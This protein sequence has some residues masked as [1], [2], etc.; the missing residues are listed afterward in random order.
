MRRLLPYFILT[1][2]S[3]NGLYPIDFSL[4][5]AGQRAL[6]VA[7]DLNESRAQMNGAIINYRRDLTQYLPQLSLTFGNSEN[8]RMD[9][10]DT[11]SY[12]ASAEISQPIFNGGRNI[13]G[14][15]LTRRQLMQQQNQLDLQEETVLDQ[16]WEIYFGILSQKK[17]I[18]LYTRSLAIVETQVAVSEV[19]FQLGEM[20]E[21]DFLEGKIQL[22]NYR[23]SIAQE[24]LTLTQ[25]E[26]QLK[27]LLFLEQW[28]ELVLTDDL[29]MDYT[30]IEIPFH[31]DDLYEMASNNN[32]SIQEAQINLEAL[33]SQ[34]NLN[35]LVFMPQISLTA[36]YQLSDNDLPLQNQSYG[37]SLDITFPFSNLPI[38]A[39]IGY[40][41]KPDQEFGTTKNISADVPTDIS[42]LINR[43]VNLLTYQASQDRLTST[44]ENLKADLYYY[45]KNL[46]QSKEMLEIL[47]EEWL[48]YRR[49]ADLQ[50]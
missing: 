20:T 27:R 8:I 16:V 48:L 6:E 40:N 25:L 12:K 37:F 45:V 32:L 29:S 4:L 23:S 49:R 9:A 36:Q 10:S 3:M 5:Q 2:F 24:E 39:S 19:Q 22:N 44:I 33:R 14:R 28:D 43:R 35:R 21:L 41:E 47:K 1:V 17:K 42:H 50:R 26:F 38:T 15:S 34:I 30:G 18:D 46:E 13:A 31:I 11:Y 7:P